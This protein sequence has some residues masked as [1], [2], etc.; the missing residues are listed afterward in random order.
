[1][2]P[3]L[4]LFGAGLVWIFLRQEGET[5][6]RIIGFDRRRLLPDMGLALALTAAQFVIILIFNALWGLFWPVVQSPQVAFGPAVFRLVVVA[7]T[8]GVGE[9]LIW[10]GYGQ[11]RLSQATRSPF[12]GILVSNFGFGLFHVNP[13]SAAGAFVNG[14]FYSLVYLRTRRLF[15]IMVSH[16]L[17][18]F[19]LFLALFLG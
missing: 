3:L 14:L 19:V 11:S 6:Y 5:L 4:H 18:D 7:L 10:R 17:I 12:L 1:M 15:P 13:F 2:I 8:A 16:W 9:E